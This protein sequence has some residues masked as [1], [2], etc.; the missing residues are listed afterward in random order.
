[1]NY[2]KFNEV[3]CKLKQAEEE[4]NKKLQEAFKP[5]IDEINRIDKEERQIDLQAQIDTAYSKGL[6]DARNAVLQ[7]YENENWYEIFGSCYNF[8]IL[9]NHSMAEII[10]KEKQLKAEKEKQVKEQELRVGDEI[11]YAR[12]KSRFEKRII[13][14]IEDGM[15]DSEKIIWSIDVELSGH[16]FWFFSTDKDVE[17]HKTGKHYDSI[18]FPKE[19]K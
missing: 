9:N 1:M 19:I 15:D 3:M 5:F 16:R 4:F 10:E 14:G 6:E 11:E 7:L 2:E 17:Y 13:I 12:S 8:N 18:P